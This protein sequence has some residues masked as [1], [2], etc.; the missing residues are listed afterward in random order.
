M[1]IQELGTLR[2]PLG[3]LLISLL[4]TIG[5]QITSNSLTSPGKEDST[6]Y[7]NEVFKY[8]MLSIP[9]NQAVLLLETQAINSRQGRLSHRAQGS[10]YT[11]NG[12]PP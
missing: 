11:F 3:I 6:E 2:G 5:P 4:L 9:E 1:N 7:K 12:F 10:G 8:L